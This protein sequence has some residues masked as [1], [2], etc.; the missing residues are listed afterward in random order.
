MNKIMLLMILCASVYGCAKQEIGY[1][2][3]SEAE[4]LPD[5]VVFKTVLNPDDPDDARRIK[6]GIPYISQRIQKI[7]GT[8]PIRYSIA[9]IGC[10]AENSAYLEQFRL[11]GKA[12]VRLPFDHTVPAGSYVFS[13][14]VMN[15]GH[16][17]VLDSALTVVLK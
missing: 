7:Q 16:S 5:T 1:L 9:R 15:E 13:I 17:A 6:F 8:L 14:A 10:D 4:Y 2:N 3:V 11:T 12:Q